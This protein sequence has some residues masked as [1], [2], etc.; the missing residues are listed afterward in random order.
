MWM[1]LFSL[2]QWLNKISCVLIWCIDL[3][4]GLTALF[5]ARNF[6]LPSTIPDIEGSIK[7][8]LLFAV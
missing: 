8:L 5:Y 6:T 1:G 4:G 2:A 3:A 7:Q